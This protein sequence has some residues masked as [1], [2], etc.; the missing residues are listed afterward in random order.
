MFEDEGYNVLGPTRQ[1]MDLA[2]SSS[3]RSYLKKYSDTKIDILVNNA[4]INIVSELS[5]IKDEEWDQVLSVNLKA[6]RIILQIIVEKM[7]E[8]KWGRV[9]NVGSL[10]SHI[11]REGRGSYTASK[12]ALR[13]LTQ[14]WALE[15]APFNILVNM[16]CPGFVLTDLT[17]ETNTPEQLEEITNSIPIKKL[18][19]PKDIAEVV[20]FL[21]SDRNNYITGQSIIVDGGYLCQ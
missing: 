13:G 8:S 19:D 2:Y 10:Y 16:V 18:A 20:F 15:L 5:D 17:K 21:A 6:P 12:S 4:G 3:I 14:T 7:K 11:S 1:E 9:V